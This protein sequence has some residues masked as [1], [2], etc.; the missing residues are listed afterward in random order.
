MLLDVLANFL[1]LA[2]GLLVL[3]VLLMIIIAA[4]KKNAVAAPYEKRG[5]LLTEAEQFFYKH[6]V[7]AAPEG[8]ILFSKVRMADVLKV[9]KGI[10][11]SDRQTAFNKISSKHFD[12]VLCHSS[13]FE[14]Q[15][16]IELD[17]KSHNSS[18]AKSKDAFIDTAC[19]SAS[20]PII[21]IKASSTYEVSMLRDSMQAV[22][23]KTLET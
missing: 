3:A 15:A 7:Q 20:I 6:L 22:L 14:V 1:P 2:I 8:S 16:V 23:E 4:F 11:K 12:F 21:R 17:D 19:S 9:Q 10:N 5:P 18:K 13:S